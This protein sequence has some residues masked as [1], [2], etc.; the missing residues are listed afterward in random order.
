LEAAL[1]TKMLA[2]VPYDRPLE[3]L[4]G[5]SSIYVFDPNDIR[6]EFSC[7]PANGE[8]EP[9]IVPQVTQSKDEALVELKT[10]TGDRAWLDKAT[11]GLPD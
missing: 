4:P 7:Q 5:I 10:L 3:I 8:G 11:A 9:L 6:L 2:P 1:H